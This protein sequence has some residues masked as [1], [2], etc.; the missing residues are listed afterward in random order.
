MG[1]MDAF[2]SEERVTLTY[3]QFYSLV[4][5]ATKAELLF[6]CVKCKVSR[7]VMYAMATGKEPEESLEGKQMII[8]G[9]IEKEK[10]EEAPKSTVQSA[11]LIK[12]DE[13]TKGDCY[14]G[15]IA[16]TNSTNDTE[17]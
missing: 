2:T 15:K 17:G 9:S 1:L 11:E 3:S 4:R 10:K 16:D 12:N 6:N 14:G 7:D 13:S 5:E 8:I